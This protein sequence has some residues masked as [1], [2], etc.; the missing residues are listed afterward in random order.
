MYHRGSPD[1]SEHRF[2]YSTRYLCRLEFRRRKS[3]STAGPG[4]NR[5][6]GD[7]PLTLFAEAGFGT[8]SKRPA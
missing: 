5:L 3:R 7:E 1:L 8:G 4:A 6:T 2:A